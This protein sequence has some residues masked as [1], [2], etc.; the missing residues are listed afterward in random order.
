MAEVRERSGDQR[1]QEPGATSGRAANAALVVFSVFV[2]LAAVEGVLTIAGYEYSPLSIEAGPGADAREYHLFEDSS[3]VYDPDAIWRPKSGFSVFNSQGFRGPEVAARKE[4][5]SLRIF[6]VGDSNTLGWPGEDGGNWPA[7]VNDLVQASDPD[8]VVVN[9][10]VWGYSSYQ[11]LIRLRQVLEFDPDLVLIS[12][13]SNDAH[14]ATISDQ[15]FAAMPVRSIGLMRALGEF[16]LGQLVLALADR[17]GS[18]GI[19][20]GARVSLEDYRHNLIAMIE[21]CTD[22]G[23]QV[24][25]MTRPYAGPVGSALRW[26]TNAHTYNAATRDVA[27]S[28]GVGLIDLYSIFKNKDELF[29]DES[30][31]TDEGHRIA[32]QIVYED[33]QPFLRR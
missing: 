32:A 13:G 18:G 15:E 2:T 5:G 20:V 25:L 29:A 30:H 12:F 23:A 7:G 21:A 33:L 1:P 14:P 19:E 9:A 26:K 8:A 11:G 4:P 6:T 3:F 27:R 31:F 22:R 10:G 24:V 28:A 17:S 16:R